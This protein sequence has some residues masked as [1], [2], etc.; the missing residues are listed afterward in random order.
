M[1]DDCKR[2]SAKGEKK[3]KKIQ[4]YENSKYDIYNTVIKCWLSLLHLVKHPKI[5]Q[6]L[7]HGFHNRFVFI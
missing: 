4:N 5:K 2:R 3:R 1:Q 7:L 6:E